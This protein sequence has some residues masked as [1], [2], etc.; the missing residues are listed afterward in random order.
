[1]LTTTGIIVAVILMAILTA[2]NFLGVKQLAAT[3]SATT[4]WKIAVP[5]LTILVLALANFDTQQL[6][7]RQ[8][9]QPRTAL[10]GILAAVSTSGIIFSYLGFE[11]ADQLAGEAAN[12]KRDI[13]FAIIGS[14]L[15]RHG[16]LH[17]AAG[18]VPGR[19]ARA[20]RSATPGTQV[21]DGLYTTLHRPVRRGR[22]PAQHRLAGHD[23]LRRRDH[24][25]G[26]HRPDLHH[27]QLAGGLRPVAQRLRPVG[28]RVDQHARRPVGRPDRGLRHRLHL[29]PAVPELAV[30]GRADHQRLAC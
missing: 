9:L 4:W 22:D 19:P 6:H 13:P 26:R 30:A 14:I 29:L 20:A 2:I 18:R 17:P 10:K 21:G 7:R 11:Q 28:L 12:P 25:P 15:H 8:R 3:N 27:R 23:H 5:L 24:H 1:M 16:H